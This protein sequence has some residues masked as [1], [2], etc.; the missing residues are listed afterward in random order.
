MI[1]DDVSMKVGLASSNSEVL[2]VALTQ[3]KD[4]LYNGGGWDD[5]GDGLIDF[6]NYIAHNVNV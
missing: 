1:S 5:N 6:L 4:L 2:K 3:N